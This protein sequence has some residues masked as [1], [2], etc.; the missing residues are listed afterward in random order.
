M[1]TYE[2]LSVAIRH[3][4]KSNVAFFLGGDFNTVLN[5]GLRGH[6]LDEFFAEHNLTIINGLPDDATTWTVQLDWLSRFIIACPC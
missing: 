4:R 6:K 5:H 3:A 1:Q 2:Q